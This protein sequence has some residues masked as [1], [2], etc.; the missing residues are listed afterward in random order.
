MI[1]NS[2]Y[3]PV[4]GGAANASANLAREL[5]HMGQ[6]VAVLT[7]RYD[8]LPEEESLDGIIIHRTWSVRRSKSRSGPFEQFSFLMGAAT[9]GLNFIR[10]WG[11]DLILCFFGI[12]SGPVGLLAKIFF[13]TSYLVS[14]RGSDVPGFRPYDF[15]TYHTIIAPLLRVVW[16]R[17]DHVIANSEGLKELANEFAPNIPI[18]VIPNGVDIERFQSYERDW[19]APNLLFVGRIVYQKGLDLLLKALGGLQHIPWKLTLVGDGPFIEDLKSQ[20]K[21]EGILDRVK[22]SGW[23]EKDQL[24]HYYQEANIFVLPSRHEGMSNALLE[25]MAMGLPIVASDIAGNEELIIQGDQ[26]Y[27]F[28]S[29]NIKE[30]RRVLKKIIIDEDLRSNLGTQSRNKIENKYTWQNSANSY[31][32]LSYKI[33]GKKLFV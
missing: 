5:S 30:L 29:N 11:P 8:D 31:L 12:P 28:S 22:F 2:E 26:G 32:D 15:S 24:V 17:A 25:A 10:S 19:S 27:L 1:I 20:A 13:G 14:L 18:S 9:E 16:R 23:V 21:R 3:P 6:D 4:G 7:C 33:I